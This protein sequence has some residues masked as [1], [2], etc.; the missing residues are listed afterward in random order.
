MAKAGD[1]L[2]ST[3]SRLWL[4]CADQV[5]APPKN[6]ALQFAHHNRPFWGLLLLLFWFIIQT[7]SNHQSCLNLPRN[8]DI[9]LTLYQIRLGG[10]LFTYFFNFVLVVLE[11][12]IKVLFILGKWATSSLLSCVN[13]WM[14]VCEP[15]VLV[16]KP[17]RREHWIP[18]NWSYKLLWA[19]P[20]SSA[21]AAS[22]LNCWTIFLV[23]CF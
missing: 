7:G 17:T 13:T 6:H 19:T 16:P 8:W 3:S 20:G 23:P 21:R 14:H 1:S 18:W 12:E 4:C 22:P 15:C 5:C 2:K 9:N 11:S 10:S